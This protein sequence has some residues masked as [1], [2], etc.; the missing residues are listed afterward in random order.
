MF[1]KM[2][3][4]DTVRLVRFRVKHS[5]VV[6]QSS[7]WPFSRMQKINSNGKQ[8]VNSVCVLHNQNLALGKG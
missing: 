3:K 2:K 6:N 8:H 4:I 7:V 5:S 1:T